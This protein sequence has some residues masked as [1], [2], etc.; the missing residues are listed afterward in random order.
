MKN[1]LKPI[2]LLISIMFFSLNVGASEGSFFVDILYL[3]DGKT[4]SDAADYFKKVE[5]VVQKHG[6]RR[7]IPGLQMENHMK[8]EIKADLINV[9][10][11]TDSENTFKNIFKDPEYLQYVKMRNATFDMSRASMFTAQ[12]F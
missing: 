8:G 2:T 9:W 4:A 5:P 6:L 10:M 1:I 12:P 3:Q 7:I 11:V